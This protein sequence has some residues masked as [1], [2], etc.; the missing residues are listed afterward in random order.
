MIPYSTSTDIGWRNDLLN[1]SKVEDSI[2]DETLYTCGSDDRHLLYPGY[3]EGLRTLNA[4]Y[5]EGLVL[6]P[7]ENII[8]AHKIALANGRVPKHYNTGEIESESLYGAALYALRDELLVNAV[9]A[10]AGQFDTV[11]NSKFS[12]YMSSGGSEIIRERTDKLNKIK[13]LHY[14]V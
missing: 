10:P 3:S 7:A 13:D 5:N 4:W 2:T 6:E 8:N 12:D 9:I 14:T 11:Y 1:V